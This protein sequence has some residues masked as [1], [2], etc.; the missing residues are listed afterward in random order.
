VTNR[1]FPTENPGQQGKNQVQ[2]DF[3]SIVWIEE[4]FTSQANLL[5]L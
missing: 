4:P 1:V 2:L 5:E 3:L